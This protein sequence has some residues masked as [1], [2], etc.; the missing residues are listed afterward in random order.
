MADC[1]ACNLCCKLLQVPD[2]NK[3]ARMLCWWTDIHGGCQRHKE[4][5]TDPSLQACRQFKCVWL[6]SQDHEDET[7]RGKRFMRPDQ[8]H[9]VFGPFDREDPLLLY[10]QVDPEHPSAWK[11]PHVSAYLEEILSK[12]AKVEIIIDEIRIR[13]PEEGMSHANVAESI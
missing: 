5:E 4:K 9:V 10:V 12:G 13:F 6:A 11:E 8:T 7:K 3:P 2:I 1:G